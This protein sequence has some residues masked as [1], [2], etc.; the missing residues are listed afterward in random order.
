MTGK[1]DTT[2]G[3]RRARKTMATAMG[4]WQMS[5]QQHRLDWT[6]LSQQLLL[7]LLK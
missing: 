4:R 2:M 3:Y 5:K 1:I 7:G 6:R